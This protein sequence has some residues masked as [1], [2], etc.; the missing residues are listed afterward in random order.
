MRA[1][2]EFCVGQRWIS[3]TEAG[4]GLGV[5]LGVQDRRVAICFPAVDEDRVY[6]IQSAPLSRI[7]YKVD[8]Q[9]KDKNQQPL[10]ILDVHDNNGLMFYKV[11]NDAGEEGILPEMDL[12]A[13]VHFSNPLDRMLFGQ[14]DPLKFFS[15]RQE[16]RQLQAEYQQ[17]GAL[18]LMGPRVQLL[19]HQLYIADQ[20]AKR[21]HPRVLLAD[22]VGLGK[23]IEAG[24]IIHQQLQSG[25]AER[26]LI[27]VPDSL[28]HQWLVEMLRRFNLSFS[29]LDEA[30]CHEL[31]HEQT[32]P[33]ETRQLVLVPGTFFAEHPERVEQALACSWDLMVVDEAHHIKWTP[34][35]S[36][37]EYQVV[38]KLAQI[39]KGVLLL[40][41]TPEQLG[42]ESHF[43]RLRLLDPDRYFDLTQFIQE[44]KSFKVVNALVDDLQV[45]KESDE[46]TLPS[47]LADYLSEQELA[48]MTDLFNNGEREAAS[49]QAMNA[50]LDRHGTGRVLFRNTRHTVTGFP[51]RKLHTYAF[52]ALDITSGAT[53]I[54]D[55]LCCENALGDTWLQDDARVD[56]LVDLLQ[57]ILL[58]K[59]VLLICAQA[60]TAMALEEFIRTRHGIKS[61]VFHEHLS[62]VARDRAAAYF[63]DQEESAQILIC[64]EIGSE[65]RNF[66]FASHM[67]MFDLPLNPDLLE[68]RIGR[69][70]RIGQQ[71]DIH[72]HVPFYEGSSTAGLLQWLDQGLNAFEQTCAIGRSVYEQFEST[73]LPLLLQAD[74]T[75]AFSQLIEDTKIQADQLRQM[76]QEGRDKLLELNS[77]RP[78][79]A[80][81]VIDRIVKAE[82]RKEL[83]D[84]MEDVADQLGIDI[85]SHD[86]N[87]I[88]LR[89]SENMRCGLLPG[90]RDEGAT[91]TFSRDNAL[92][93]EDLGFLTWEHPTVVAAMDH[94][95][96]SEHGNTAVATIK[97]KPL[98]PGTL[99][100]ETIFRVNSIAAK[101]LQLH[102]FLPAQATRCL[103]NMEGK[104]LSHILT[105]EK[106]AE[107]VKK[108]PI[109]KA[110]A[111]AKQGQGAIKAMAELTMSV[112]GEKMPTIKA[113]ALKQMEDYQTQELQRLEALAQVNP[114][115]RE[116]ELTAIKVETEALRTAITHSELSLDAIRFIMAV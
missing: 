9:V 103:V 8:D 105:E 61:A 87:S 86:I 39:A 37:I 111:L 42:V 7:I 14:I 23:T 55:A 15:L 74:D 10:T 52:P 30:I 26:V 90:M 41:A 58:G 85:E 43:A 47:Q 84:Y 5:V 6:A 36:S 49:D 62:L 113:E 12:D 38:E 106:L 93:R 83:E 76:M 50:L 28:L 91:Y 81:D 108:V 20:V 60:S 94:V 66:Q 59:K 35:E 88:I 21:Q 29:V 19:P 73:L 64:S 45:L 107:L 112:V 101:H 16:T 70:D 110:Q 1:L 109:I 69:L 48:A 115:I 3:N 13:F 98:P 25:A 53:D 51:E 104:D 89:P 116:D 57:G 31:A 17:S 71:R 65:G 2:S 92:S 72:I 22:E 100:L 68:Q 56:W 63:A 18:G 102:R 77:C 79:A 78:K 40:T 24:L 97:L 33:F 32:N 82:K 4:L 99:L 67:I 80:S 34:T 114:N 75:A 54:H 95:L 27:V 11:L 46:D 44:E 96:S